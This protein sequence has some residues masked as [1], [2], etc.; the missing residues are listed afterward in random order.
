[1]NEHSTEGGQPLPEER[2]S[3]DQQLLGDESDLD[4]DLKKTPGKVVIPPPIPSTKDLG[5]S[6]RK[7]IQSQNEPAATLKPKARRG[8]LRDDAIED[9]QGNYI[10]SFGRAGCGKTTFQ[11]YLLYYLTHSDAFNSSLVIAP[12]DTATGWDAQRIYN[13]WMA[14]WQIGQFPDATA[15]SEDAIRELTVAATPRVGS[16][17]RLTLSFL[18]IA[19]ELMERILPTDQ[20]DPE[21]STTLVR[22]L[23]NERINFTILLFIEPTTA[24]KD[25]VLFDNLFTYLKVNFPHLVSS[26]SLGVVI[27]KPEASLEIF[28]QRFPGFSHY[29]TLKGDLCEDYIERMTPR[30]FQTLNAWDR[31]DQVQIMTMSLGD[32]EPDEHGKTSYVARKDFHDIEKIFAWLYKQFTGE[33]LGLKWWQQWYKWIRE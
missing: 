12:E 20:K 32:V 15:A 9:K 11:S 18:E 6:S 33:R 3:L 4:S 14:K 22:Y 10:I 2:K 5:T 8:A 7:P 30:L 1:M 31:P 25:D 21:L 29:A 16:C 28:K 17:A 24:D 27:S 23:Q 19:G 26:M 13:N